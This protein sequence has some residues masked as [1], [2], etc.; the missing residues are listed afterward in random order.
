MPIKGGK[1]VRRNMKR[2]VG[3]ITGP[4]TNKALTEVLV[5]GEGYAAELTPVDTSNLINSRFRTVTDTQ[6][7]AV[8]VV[9][10]TASYAIFVH[11]GG[12]KNWKKAGAEDEFLR[13][14]FEENGRAEIEAHVLRSYRI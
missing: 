4:L 12:Q 2:L 10:Y 9:G 7:G 14:G 8:G 1:K 13:K 6:T 11:E 3:R 5:I